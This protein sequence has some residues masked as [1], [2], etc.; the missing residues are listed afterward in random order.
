M[1]KA[2]TDLTQSVV[3]TLRVL[4][5]EKQRSVLDFAQFLVRQ[6]DTQTVQV[7]EREARRKAGSWLLGNVSYMAGVEEVG[8][9][10]ERDGRAVWRFNA[11]LTGQSHP[12]LGPLG[13]VDV[14]ATTGEVLADSRLARK[15]I[16]HGQALAASL[17]S[18]AR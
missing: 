18:S 2:V 10:V 1:A 3:E 5:V 14:D 4:P 15:L 7:D 12:A 6:A 8:L 16:K 11:F 17:S 9:L 13:Q